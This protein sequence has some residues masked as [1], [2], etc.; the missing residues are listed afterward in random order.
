MKV[1]LARSAVVLATANLLTLAG[2]SGDTDLADPA[3]A[4]VLSALTALAAEPAGGVCAT[5][6]TKITAGLDANLNKLL[7]PAEVSYTSYACNGTV[8]APGAPGEASAAGLNSLIA[9]TPEPA[10][11][12]CTSGG[13]RISSGLDTNADGLLGDSEN[14]RTLY[15][16]NG[17][18]GSAVVTSP[19]NSDYYDSSDGK[20]FPSS[21]QE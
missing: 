5:G 6:G 9:V 4:Q 1:K 20:G 18:A 2:C 3:G 16:C 19:A 15:A 10:G 21:N 11:A 7:D 8:P 14:I 17:A 12:N 13:S